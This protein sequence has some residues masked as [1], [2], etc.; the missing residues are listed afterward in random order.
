M[1]RVGLMV[2]FLVVVGLMASVAFVCAADVNITG[3]WAFTVVTP[4]G[5][6]TPTVTFE[7]QAEKLTGQY[8][9]SIGEA[10]LTG[11]LKNGEI[12]FQFVT[13]PKLGPAIY[14]GKVDP[15]D[16]QKMS[17]TVDFAGQAK[18]TW[19]GKKVK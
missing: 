9:G 16:P 8:A 6:G 4:K 2:A 7:Q 3:K 19:E 17:G 10:P 5:N 13:D 18:G 12:S 1:K 15:A 11:T 14:T